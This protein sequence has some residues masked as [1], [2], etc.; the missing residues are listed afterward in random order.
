M[1]MTYKD[2]TIERNGYGYYTA[3]VYMRDRINGGFYFYPIQADTLAGIK[4]SI[5][6][7]LSV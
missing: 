7:Y 4:E 5:S 6:Y 1:N 3:M 2:T